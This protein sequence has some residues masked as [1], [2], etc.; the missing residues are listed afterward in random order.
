[1][2]AA[3]YHGPGDIRIES[4][5]EPDDPARGDVVIEVA[6][7]AICGTDAAEWAHGPLLAR[8]PVVLGHEFVGRVVATGSAVEEIAIGERIVCGAG[9]LWR[10]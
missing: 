5:A 3:V 2:R 1:M 9:F 4:I 10:V 6:R 7:A 8:P